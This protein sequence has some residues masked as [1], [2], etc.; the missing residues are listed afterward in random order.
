MSSHKIN[1]K[2]L[3][4]ESARRRRGE[5]SEAGQDLVFTNGCYDLLH[6]GHLHY[7]QSSRDLG[8]Q[9][10]VVINDDASVRALKG[11]H[12]PILKAEHRAFCLAALECVDLVIISPGERI[13]NEI[14]MLQPDI[15]TKAGDYTYE[16][17]H[18]GER[19]AL[20]AVGA[21]IVFL[22]FWSGFST[23]QM[24]KR[25]KEAE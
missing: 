15:Y 22:P 8:D 11:P 23:T 16:T 9:L 6:P 10:W 19:N 21:R 4:L 2:L 7:L 25:I 20:D 12:R 17:L 3:D 5:L 14:N 18:A 1:N 24:I 13:I